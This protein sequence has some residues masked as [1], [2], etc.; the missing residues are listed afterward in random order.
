MYLIF[1]TYTMEN[2]DK[3][4]EDNIILFTGYPPTKS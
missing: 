1:I 2:S 4:S 3:I